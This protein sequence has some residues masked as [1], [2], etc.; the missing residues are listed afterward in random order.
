MTSQPAC[1]NEST[2]AV[3]TS[4][5]APVINTVRGILASVH[6]KVDLLEQLFEAGIF[7]GHALAELGARIRSR[8][9]AQAGKFLLSSEARRVGKESVSTCRS[10]WSPYH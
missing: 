4:P 6:H 2:A 3:P 9:N 8:D 10:R 7:I 5:L 1:R